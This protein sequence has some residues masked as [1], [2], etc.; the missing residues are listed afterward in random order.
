MKSSMKTRCLQ[1]RSLVELSQ[2]Q[3]LGS[4]Y[5]IWKRAEKRLFNLITKILEP[6]LRTDGREDRKHLILHWKICN[7][8]LGFALRVC[9]VPA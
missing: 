1:H 6:K 2:T 3:T 4:W 7:G 8:S 9:S 5:F